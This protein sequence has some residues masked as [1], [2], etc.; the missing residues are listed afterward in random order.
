MHGQRYGDQDVPDQDNGDVGRRVVGAM[1]GNVETADRAVWVNF[2]IAVEKRPAA[3][4][5]AAPAD[6]AAD[7][8][9]DRTLAEVAAE[10]C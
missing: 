8:F 6:T 5:G 4:L 2:Q 7:G 10:Y 9:A 3:A 1:A